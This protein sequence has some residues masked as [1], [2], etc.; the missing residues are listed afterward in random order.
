MKRVNS[1]PEKMVFI[2]AILILLLL[3]PLNSTTGYSQEK[4]LMFYN[5]ENLFDTIDCHLDDDEFLPSSP[6]RWGSYRYYSKL[7]NLFRVIVTAN[8]W[9]LPQ[10]IGLCEVENKDVIDDL[11]RYTYL[12]R[13]NYT[14]IFAESADIRGIGVALL[15][16]TS[17]FTILDKT[18]VVPVDDKGEAMDTRSVLFARLAD[19]IDTI[20]VV[21]THWPSRWG[22][23][24]ATD[25]LRARVAS[26]I[27]DELELTRE[28]HG[29]DEKI[30]VMGDLNS[31]PD[32]PVVTDVLGTES[33]DRN[34][35]GNELVNL[36]RYEEETYYGTYKYRGTWSL[37]D[38]IIV[39]GSLV[40]SSA[41]YSIS[42]EGYRIFSD[43][44]LLVPDETYNGFK[45]FRT[46]RG[47]VWEGGYSDHLPVLVTVTCQR[48]DVE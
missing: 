44:Y 47:P 26:L 37:F 22:G 16:D 21:V 3:S 32:D 23:V 10:V 34:S 4:T 25:P 19:N 35:T 8:G 43:S 27:S 17:S 42:G 1:F 13:H 39:S 12:S 29:R 36:S 28:K 40:N 41:G 5:V 30:I 11:L 18:V 15:V 24:A 9:N 20:T 6:R 38:Q 7:N 33:S 14:A 48:P 45:P 2:P 46:W 31:D